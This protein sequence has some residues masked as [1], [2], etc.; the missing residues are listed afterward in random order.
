MHLTRPQKQNSFQ[1][2][3]SNAITSIASF[4]AQLKSDDSK[5]EIK[6]QDMESALRKLCAAISE[7]KWDLLRIPDKRSSRNNADGDTPPTAN[8]HL[9]LSDQELKALK[10]SWIL[11]GNQLYLRAFQWRVPIL[12]QLMKW[13]EQGKIICAPKQEVHAQPVDE[14][15]AQKLCFSIKNGEYHNTTGNITSLDCAVMLKT[16]HTDVLKALVEANK[17]ALLAGLKLDPSQYAY[18]LLTGNHEAGDNVFNMEAFQG[19]FGIDTKNTFV[20]VLAVGH[21]KDLPARVKDLQS[22]EEIDR[23]IY[24]WANEKFGELLGNLSPKELTQKIPSANVETVQVQKVQ[25]EGKPR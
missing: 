8:N 13:E 17:D 20:A 24:Q 16:D 7:N 22:I 19:I 6:E 3:C 5:P 2:Q 9:R 12:T 11:F 18:Q 21:A 23:A 15:A 10:E 25:G 14:L 1:T 4:S